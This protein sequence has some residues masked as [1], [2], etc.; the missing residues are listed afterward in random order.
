MLV[1]NEKKQELHSKAKPG[2]SEKNHKQSIEFVSDL[3]GHCADMLRFTREM[4]KSVTPADN[5]WEVGTAL[6]DYER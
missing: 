5:E 3:P 4:W 1:K 2:K 6:L